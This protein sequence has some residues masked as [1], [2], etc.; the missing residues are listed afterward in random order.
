MRGDLTTI[1][2]AY[3]LELVVAAGGFGGVVILVPRDVVGPGGDEEEEEEE[4]TEA[5]EL[6]K[7]R[8]HGERSLHQT[9]NLADFAP[10]FDL[11]E[12]KAGR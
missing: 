1:A 8:S 4:E 11:G 3:Q 2:L 5:E 12:E 9:L 10:N 6:R 7:T